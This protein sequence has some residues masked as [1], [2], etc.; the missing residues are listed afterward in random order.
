MRKICAAVTICFVFVA[1]APFSFAQQ[2]DLKQEIDARTRELREIHQQIEETQDQLYETE[3][4]GRTLKQDISRSNYSINQLNLTIKSSKIHVEKL[5]LEINSLDINIEDAQKSIEL[6]KRAINDILRELQIKGDVSVVETLLKNQSLAE[7]LNEIQSLAELRNL[8]ADDIENLKGLKLTLG[9][10]LNQVSSKKNRVERESKSSKVKKSLLE[11]ERTNNKELLAFTASQTKAYGE[12]IN[13]LAKRQEEIAREI[14]AMEATL[15]KQINTDLLP[16]ERPGVLG[17]PVDGY[18]R[19]TQEYGATAFARY[20]YKGKWHNGI[21]IGAPV[22]TSVLSAGE[23]LVL[24]VGNQDKYCPEGAYG[25]FVVV[26][27]PNNLVTLYAHL[28]RIAV[29]PGDRVERGGVV[30][31]IG[32]TGYSTGYHLHFTVYD[33]NTF[34]MG[35]SRVC[36]PMPFGGDIDPNKYL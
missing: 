16:Q 29:S 13:N 1:I 14:E 24:S 5:G 23:G 22:G 12:L 11:T 34:R 35:P 8:L 32:T 30:G 9:G 31:Y 7:G 27:H 17:W 2:T 18:K 21:D 19:V 10:Q 4:K 26:R 28:S 36:G 33:G 25:K 15:R 6:K 3:K 20:A